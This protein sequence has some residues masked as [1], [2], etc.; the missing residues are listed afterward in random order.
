MGDEA[1][2]EVKIFV[3]QKGRRTF[4]IRA[5]WHSLVRVDKESHKRNSVR[6]RPGPR[7]ARRGAAK[8]PGTGRQNVV[9][10][11]LS[12]LLV[13]QLEKTTGRDD[14]LP[15]VLVL[16]QDGRTAPL[17]TLKRNTR[18]KFNRNKA[19]PFPYVVFPFAGPLT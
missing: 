19:I 8:S 10:P 4:V 16:A 1:G 17:R 9:R 15:S 7:R 13:G 14:K 18:G 11:R 5:F 2:H 6:S 12:F 3:I